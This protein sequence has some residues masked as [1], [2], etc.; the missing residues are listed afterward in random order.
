[1]DAGFDGVN[2]SNG[3]EMLDPQV[4]VLNQCGLEKLG[5]IQEAYPV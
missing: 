1:M 4:K 2:E 5:W 3:E